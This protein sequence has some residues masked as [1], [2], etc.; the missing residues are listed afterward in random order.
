MQ[1]INIGTS[2]T[3]Q[4]SFINSLSLEKGHINVSFNDGGEDRVDLPSVDAAKAEFERISTLLV[5]VK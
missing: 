4:V 2:Y 5:T 1:F 3:C